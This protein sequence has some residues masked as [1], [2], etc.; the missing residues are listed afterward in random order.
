MTLTTAADVAAVV[1]RAVD[2]KSEWPEIGGIRGNGVTFSQ[3]IEI[4]EK[5]RGPSITGQ[6]NRRSSL[7]NMS[8]YRPFVYH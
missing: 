3:I 1:A 6:V 7:F 2:Y 4:G 8:Y 5:I